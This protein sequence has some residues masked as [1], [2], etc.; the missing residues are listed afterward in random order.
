LTTHTSAE[1]VVVAGADQGRVAAA[2]QGYAS[3]KCSPSPVGVVICHPAASRLRL[4]REHVRRAV[5][6]WSRRAPI[7][8]CFRGDSATLLP[9]SLFARG[10]R[11]LSFPPGCVQVSTESA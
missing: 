6:A 10:L 11:R 1:F 7:T 2:D 9:N 5:V 4:A 3:P 8:A